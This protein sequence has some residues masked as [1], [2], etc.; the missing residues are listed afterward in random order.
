[1]DAGFK[2]ANKAR[3]TTGAVEKDPS[4][5]AIR[6]VGPEALAMVASNYLPQAA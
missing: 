6:K 4:V 1:M 2:A 3:A 5:I